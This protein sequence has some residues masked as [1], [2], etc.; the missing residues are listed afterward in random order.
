VAVASPAVL[1]QRDRGGVVQRHLA[2]LVLLCGADVQ[3]APGEVNVGSVKPERLAGTQAGDRQQPDHRLE[4]G[5][6]QPWR[7]CPGGGHQR[8]D[9]AGRVQVRSDPRQRR[10]QQILG[11]DLGRGVDRA[12]VASEAAN[13]PEPP[14]P[15]VRVRLHRCCPHQRE[16]GRDALGA[17]VVHEFDEI[18]KRPAGLLELEPKPP[19][20][21]QV[22]VRRRAQIG[23]DAPPGHGIASGLSLALSTFAY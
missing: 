20:N 3:C 16:L 8:L 19:A 10:W 4:C 12:Q 23:H 1:A 2:M 9:L 18:L 14:A 17:S 13:D 11:W 5:G 15:P 22:V 6:T 7:Q 21:G